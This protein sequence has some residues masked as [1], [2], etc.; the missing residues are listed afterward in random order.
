MKY[1]NQF[2]EFNFNRFAEGKVFRVIGQSEYKD[3]DTEA[4]LGTKIEV[5]IYKDETEYK[6]KE[7]ETGSNLFEK[8]NFKVSKDLNVTEGD[9]I[10]PVD[11]VCT[12]YGEY[13]NQLSV[14][15]S[16]IKILK[17]RSSAGQGVA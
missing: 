14:K 7:G 12:I 17:T 5:V 10:L 13:R 2:Q 6:R 3:F 15:C 9:V 4:H 1:L 16:D 11:P 8:I